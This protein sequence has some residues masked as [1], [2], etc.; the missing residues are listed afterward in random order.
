MAI[1]VDIEAN[2][3]LTFLWTSLK[4]RLAG[5][6]LPWFL[7][8]GSSRSGKTWAIISFL[9]V[10][11]MNPEILGEK[12]IRVRAYR[13]DGTTC[14]DTIAEDFIEI[15]T[16]QFGG[17]GRNGAWVSA[18]ESAGTWNKSTL[19]YTF[20]NGSTFSFH[21]ANDAQK[22]Q[23]KKAH[24]SWFNEAMEISYDAQ[25]QI[26]M[27]TT[28]LKLADW[29]PSQTTHWIFNKIMTTNS[30][31]AYCHST[32]SDNIKHLTSE[33]VAEIE[34]YKPTP[35]NLAS[36]T[37][38]KFKWSVY[39]EGKRGVRENLVFER[40]RWDVID[41]DKFPAENVCQ[42]YGFGL[43][44]GYSVDPT[45]LIECALHN[46]VIYL[47]QIIYQSRLISG[48]SYN[49]PNEP[50]VVGI[51][52]DL[53]ID[54]NAR[55]HG[56]SA[57][58]EQIAQIALAGYNIMGTPKPAGS[59]LAGIDILKHFRIL[60]CRSSQKLINEF[61]NYE[62]IKKPNGEITDQPQDKNNHGIDAV[63]YWA[64]EELKASAIVSLNKKI[65]PVQSVRSSF[66]EW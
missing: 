56:D 65:K 32:Y 14:R 64:L 2:K 16:Y 35:E 11:C 37:A 47:R 19:M 20:T 62:F 41:D 54:K 51:M 49:N 36:G 31:Y 39:G 59:I 1:N 50:S 29:N 63:R 38:D 9:A 42:R 4:R 44:F 25:F 18:F 61:E 55:I 52:D 17:E 13:N 5:E 23:G 7:L 43:D 66:D 48:R 57:A 24:I 45:A 40:Y 53:G 6:K 10:L 33:Q 58:A 60:I 15:M 27:R 12:Q 21:G 30:P 8:E 22:L 3:N 34:R 28:F 26:S 46:D